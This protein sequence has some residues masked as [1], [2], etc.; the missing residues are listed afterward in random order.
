MQYDDLVK[1]NRNERLFPLGCGFPLTG[2]VSLLKISYI[3]TE[4]I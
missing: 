2:I 1:T 3:D 4:H